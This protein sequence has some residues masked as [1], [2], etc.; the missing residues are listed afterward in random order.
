LHESDRITIQNEEEKST[1]II[2]EV[3]DSDSAKY[4]VEVKNEFGAD[5]SYTSLAVKGKYLTFKHF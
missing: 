1:L 5:Y 4:D 3:M 2:K